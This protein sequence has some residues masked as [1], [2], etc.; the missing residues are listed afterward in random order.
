[1]VHL[2]GRYPAG[3]IEFGLDLLTTHLFGDVGNAHPKHTNWRWS[4]TGFIVYRQ[5]NF[6]GFVDIDIK[7]LILP[8]VVPGC[9]RSCLNGIF[10]FENHICLRTSRKSGTCRMIHVLDGLNAHGQKTRQRLAHV[11]RAETFIWST[12][13]HLVLLFLKLGEMVQALRTIRGFCG[14]NVDMQV[15]ITLQGLLEQ[16]NFLVALN[17]STLG[18]GATFPIPFILV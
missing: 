11:W 15:L 7:R 5:F 10:D 4:I 2:V 8:P 9:F 16:L 1:M 6:V 14:F 18:I 17:P 12:G 13:Q 3:S